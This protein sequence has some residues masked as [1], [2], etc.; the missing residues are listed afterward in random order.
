MNLNK[1]YIITVDVKNATVSTPSNMSFYITDVKTS[2]I[3]AQLVFNE[4][5]NTLIKNYA[6]VENAEDFEITLRLIKPNNDFKE[7]KFT[8][9][10]Q[11]EAFFMVNLTDEYK[12]YIGT[13]NCEFFVDSKV[14]DEL[15]RIT[16]GS[17]RYNVLPS[18]ANS[19]DDVIEGDPD[20][21]LLDELLD[22]VESIDVDSYATKEYVDEAVDE[23]VSEDDVL[24]MINSYLGTPSDRDSIALSA[25][26][27][28]Q[29]KID[30][31][32]DIRTVVNTE[33]DIMNIEY[34]YVGMIVYVRDTGKRYEILTL[35]D[36][37][38][39]L[40]SIKNTVVGTYRKLDYATTAYVDEAVAN[41]GGAI[42][43]SNLVTTDDIVIIGGKE[44]THIFTPDDV[45]NEESYRMYLMK[46]VSIEYFNSEG[47]CGGIIPFDGE[48][49]EI[50]VWYDGDVKYID[51]IDNWGYYEGF[52]AD[53]NNK[54]ILDYQDSFVWQS[55]LEDYTTKEYVDEAVANAGSDIDTTNLVV[56]NSL[57]VGENCTAGDYQVVHG[58]NPIPDYY[59][60]YSHIVGNGDEN[61]SNAY[62]LDWNGNAWFAGD[63]TIGANRNQLATKEY[64]DSLIGDIEAALSAILGGEDTGGEDT[65][66][67]DWPTGGGGW[68]TGGGGA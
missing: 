42:D 46:N 20:Y 4:S 35:A 24:N 37:Q 54:L 55:G 36:K 49:I 5:N 16:T 51:I 34:P 64:V 68:P 44:E 32:L 30:S 61:P 9:L 25:P 26:F 13:Y 1:D 15:E 8:L 67:T 48:L 58:K 31:P 2:N 19:L 14:N 22:R 39:G 47:V 50:G 60:I 6:P 59:N 57:A 21:P 45:P 66:D 7:L 38:V 40:A 29:T 41:S 63:V 12:D 56:S 28:M 65:G 23:A 52:Y 43:T 10:N 17:F 33:S 18:I 62:T 3:F 53:E 11:L 27:K